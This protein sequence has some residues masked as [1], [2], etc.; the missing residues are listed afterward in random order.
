MGARIFLQ[1]RVEKNESV[2]FMA[3][4]E[5]IAVGFVQLYPTFSSVTMEKF[6]ILN[7]L[8]V[9]TTH[10]KKGIGG[11]LLIQAQKFA[12]DFKLKGLALETAKDN[13]AQ[14]LYERLGWDKDTDFYHYFWTNT[15]DK[16]Y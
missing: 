14:K 7:D 2:I 5:E 6:Y 8:F 9:T 1:R 3:I 16:L 11:R 12:V 10:R 13:P 15:G 4:E